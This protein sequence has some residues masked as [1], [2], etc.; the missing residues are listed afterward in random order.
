MLSEYALLL[1]FPKY[2]LCFEKKQLILQRNGNFEGRRMKS[3]L[4]YYR[5][6]VLD[7]NMTGR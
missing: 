4:K 6:L 3:W 7:R 5:L 2:L 1:I